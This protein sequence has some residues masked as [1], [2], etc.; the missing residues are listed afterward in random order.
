M[1]AIQLAHIPNGTSETPGRYQTTNIKG[2]S[3]ALCIVVADRHTDPAH[4]AAG[5]LHGA[6]LSGEGGP[7]TATVSFGSQK[8]FRRSPPKAPQGDYSESVLGDRFAAVERGDTQIACML[9]WVSE[10]I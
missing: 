10:M 9:Q 6:F 8:P 7:P 5:L 2:Y 1:P 3:D 4:S